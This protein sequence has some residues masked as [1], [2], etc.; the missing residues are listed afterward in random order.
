[1]NHF[2]TIDIPSYSKI[3]ESYTIPVLYSL[4]T[5]EL[6]LYTSDMADFNFDLSIKYIKDNSRIQIS[7]RGYK[8]DT[9]KPKENNKVMTKK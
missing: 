1:M 2:S 7:G 3:V 8:I 6:K 4:I 9:P 5:E